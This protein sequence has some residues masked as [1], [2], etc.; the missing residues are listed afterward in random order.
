MLFGIDIVMTASGV[1]IKKRN[2]FSWY[3]QGCISILQYLLNRGVIST[4]FLP[5]AP[6][7]SSAIHGLQSLLETLTDFY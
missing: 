5:P 3:N 2:K 4:P 1:L 6:I 7:P